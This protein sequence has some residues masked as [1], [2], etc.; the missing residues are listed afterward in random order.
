MGLL[1][2]LKNLFS[3]EKPAKNDIEIIRLGRVD[4]TNNYLR[5]YIPHSEDERFT[6]VTAEYQSDGRGQGANKWESR[7]G[8]N[9]LFSILVHPLRLPL[10]QQFLLSQAGA[11]AL[12]EA[13]NKYI[14]E[15]VTLKWPNDIYYKDSKLSGTLIETCLGAGHIK[16]FIWGVGLNVNQKQ[17]ESDAPNPISLYQILGKA[18]DKETLLQEIIATFRK[19]YDWIEQGAYGDISAMYHEALYRRKGFYRFRDKEGEFEGAIIEV[20]DDGHLILRTRQGEIRG[21]LFKEIEFVL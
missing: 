7:E 2:S 17:F 19:Y 3:S 6:V 15:D 12:K 14:P 1:Q 21:Y 5:A 9:L 11:L 20:E 4:S 16:D 8:E 18:V 13:I 10:R